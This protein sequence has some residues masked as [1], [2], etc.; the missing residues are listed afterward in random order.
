MTSMILLLRRLAVPFALLLAL[1]AAPAFAQSPA[2]TVR[3]Y[4]LGPNDAITVLVYGQQEFNV[5]TKVKP[6]GTITMPLIGTVQASGKTVVTLADE[7]KRRLVAG[8]FLRDPIV[9][10]E[11]NEYNSRWVR[12]AG[13][14]GAPS[15]VP[16]DR[17]YRLLDVLLR[18]GWVQDAGANA[19]V[20]RRAADGREQTID[21][22][23]LGRGDPTKDVLL[24]AGDTIYLPEADLVFLQGQVNRPGAFPLRPGATVRSVL[25][26]A[27]GVT[28]LGSANRFT[29][30]RGGKEI[31]ATSDTV[32]QRD[33]VLTFRERLF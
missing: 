1:A 27:G 21:V 25:A 4:V 2:A 9:N 24:E 17:P 30:T 32:L 15:L 7:V 18:A 31:E 10:V 5:Q 12:V 29:L 22:R 14:V 8:N 23:E 3:G 20:L 26:A 28:Q 6:D 19:V 33:D 11:I 16:L 13:K